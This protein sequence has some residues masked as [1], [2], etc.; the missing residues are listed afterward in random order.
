[1]YK[2]YP[3]GAPV[4]IGGNNYYVAD[5]HGLLRY[6]GPQNPILPMRFSTTS[7]FDDCSCTSCMKAFLE[8]MCSPFKACCEIFCPTKTIHKVCCMFTILIA[9][10]CII[11][12]ETMPDRY[13]PETGYLNTG[14]TLLL[15]AGLLVPL[16]TCIVC[17]CFRKENKCCQQQ[18]ENARLLKV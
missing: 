14:A 2:N 16:I 12:S 13:D 8:P 15:S 5:T 4:S 3:V 11:T 6:T 10:G 7:I 1:M 17:A 9:I 18:N